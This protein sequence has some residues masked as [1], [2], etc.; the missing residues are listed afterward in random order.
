MLAWVRKAQWWNEWLERND[1][2]TG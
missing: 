1:G 2:M